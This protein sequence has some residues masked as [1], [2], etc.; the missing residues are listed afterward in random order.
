M[1]SRRDRRAGWGGGVKGAC[2]GVKWLSVAG[3]GS[4]WP[5]LPWGLFALREE[6]QQQGFC[7]LW[8]GAGSSSA[9]VMATECSMGRPRGPLRSGRVPGFSS[10]GRYCT[11][12]E[13]VPIGAWGTEPALSSCLPLS[14]SREVDLFQDWSLGEKA[15]PKGTP[16]GFTTPVGLSTGP[17]AGCCSPPRPRLFLPVRWLPDSQGACPE[18]KG[19]RGPGPGR[20]GCTDPAP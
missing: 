9:A 6:R 7:R 19:A 1:G 11:E 17:G 4:T 10:T 18:A 2:S 3:L 8:A 13:E 20:A 12:Q 5:W 14:H 15:W 16:S